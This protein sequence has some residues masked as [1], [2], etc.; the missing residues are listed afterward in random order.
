MHSEQ[1]QID[2]PLK[3]AELIGDMS[4]NIYNIAAKSEGKVVTAR[5]E[6][7]PMNNAFDLKAYYSPDNQVSIHSLCQHFV[8]I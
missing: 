4:E 1:F 6:V 2:T 3:K 7:Q 8:K 5:L